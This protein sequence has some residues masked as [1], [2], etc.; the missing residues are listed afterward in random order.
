MPEALPTNPTI[1]LGR[2]AQRLS[3]LAFGCEQ[4]GGYEWGDVEPREILAAIEVAIEAGV[5]LFDTADCYGRGESERRLGAALAPYRERVILATKFGVRF[6]DTGGVWY[7]SSPRWAQAALEQ[8]LRRLHTEQ[9]DL[10]QMHYWDGV[11]ALPELF[12]CL[13]KLRGQSK[14]RWYGITNHEPLA[15]LQADYP[16]Y[17][18]ASFE[19]SLV[20]RSHE[21]AARRLAADG[22]TFLAYGSLGQGILSGKYRQGTRFP[23]GDRRARPHYRHFHGERFARNERIVDVLS[24]QA[25]KLGA[26]PSQ[27]AIA[28]VLRSLPH[29]AALVGFKHSQQLREALGALRLT[30][31]PDTLAA[32]AAVSAEAMAADGVVS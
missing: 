27:I 8:S 10:L 2:T 20:E 11:T 31:P 9:V 22:L 17:V 26:Q 29:S 23:A 19:Y 12:E 13:E 28:W 14:I 5:T 16:G 30:L 18:S 6:S 3:R 21:H 25:R 4:L 24:E 7:D 15:G 1:A 32:L